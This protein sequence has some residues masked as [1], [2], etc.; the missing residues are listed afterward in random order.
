M[1]ATKRTTHA[2]L[3]KHFDTLSARVHAFIESEKEARTELNATMAQILSTTNQRKTLKDEVDSLEKRVNN[4]SITNS[5]AAAIAM[6][7]GFFGI[8][9]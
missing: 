7:L 3:S 4:W 5:I 1:T 8:N 6:I 2:E 9:R